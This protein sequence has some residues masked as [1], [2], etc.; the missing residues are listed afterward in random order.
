MERLAKFGFVYRELDTQWQHIGLQMN[1]KRK[2]KI[3]F[4]DMESLKEVDENLSDEKR[5]ECVKT[6]MDLLYDR[7]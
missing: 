3:I 5:N 7:V 6:C 1:D 2:E 4:V